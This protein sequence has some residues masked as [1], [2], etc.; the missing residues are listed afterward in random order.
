MLRG[1]GWS[2]GA[3]VLGKLSVPGRPTNLNYSWARAYCAYRRCGWGF[4]GHFF[5]CLSFLLFLPLSGRRSDIDWNTVSKQPANQL[6]G[7]ESYFLLLQWIQCTS[8]AD[9]SDI[10]YSENTS[11]IFHL[12][13]IRFVTAAS[14][15][16]IDNLGLS[17]WHAQFSSN[18]TLRTYARQIKWRHILK[19]FLS[20]RKNNLHAT[21]VRGQLK[22]HYKQFSRCKLCLYPIL[23]PLNALSQAKLLRNDWRRALHP[24]LMYKIKRKFTFFR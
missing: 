17:F 1:R 15:G 3:M 5:S 21:S 6:R 18:I 12:W 13:L 23:Y 14:R 11:Y 10:V 4:F 7:R 9:K 24:P 8:K 20:S 16:C 19:S 22:W 2:V